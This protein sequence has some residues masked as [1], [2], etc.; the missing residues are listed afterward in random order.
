MDTV[1]YQIPPCLLLVIL[2]LE[3]VNLEKAFKPVPDDQQ[4]VGN[5]YNDNDR[6]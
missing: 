5:S 2:R 6:R 4:T 1:S 3:L